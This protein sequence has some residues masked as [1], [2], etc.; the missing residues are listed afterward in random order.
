MP[1]LSVTL[2]L[3]FMVIPD[4]NPG[5]DA[6]S[7]TTKVEG[8]AKT[9]LAEATSTLAEKGISLTTTSGSE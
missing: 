7:F 5:G 3:K 1:N 6:Q 2:T 8:Q 9:A 4:V